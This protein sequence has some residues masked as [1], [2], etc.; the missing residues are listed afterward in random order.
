MTTRRIAIASASAALAVLGLGVAGATPALAVAADPCTVG[1][2]TDGFQC[3][4]EP[5]ESFV[6]ILKGGNGGAGGNG[7][8]GTSGTSGDGG[9]GGAGGA[10]AKYQVVYTNTTGGTVTLEFTI[11]ANGADGAVGT[12]G[13]GN[14]GGG[15]GGGF[16]SY[17][18]IAASTIAIALGGNGGSGGDGGDGAAAGADGADATGG[19]LATT[20]TESP[21]IALATV[22]IGSAPPL[23]MQS[24]SK[25]AAEQCADG[26]SPSWAQWANEGTGGPVCNRYVL[27]RGGAWVT[28]PNPTEGPYS[29]LA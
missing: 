6:I 17:V 9:A 11:G 18:T 21:F 2:V 23:W 24:Y 3:T 4:M 15:G 13:T 20:N 27:Y 29:P 19:N 14:G 1:T 26:W 16:D 5:G 22:P 28:S 25:P 12:D 8:D 10:G 7:D